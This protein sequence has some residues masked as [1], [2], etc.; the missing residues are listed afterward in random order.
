MVRGFQ[1]QLFPVWAYALLLLGMLFGAMAAQAGLTPAGTPIKNLATVTYQ[2]T[3]GNK[4]TAQSNE[5]VVTVAEIYSADLQKEE[6]HKYGA[7]THTIYFPHQLSNKGNAENSFG[8][9]VA[10]KMP[11][12][13]IVN[14]PGDVIIYDDIDGNGQPD[15]NEPAIG[16]KKL[17]AGEVADLVLAVTVPEGVST[18]EIVITFTATA[19][20]GSPFKVDDKESKSKSVKDTVSIK[21]DIALI[22]ATKKVINHTPAKVVFKD[23]VIDKEES[24][25]GSITYEI[26]VTNKGKEITSADNAKIYDFLPEWLTVVGE[27]KDG[28]TNI[29]SDGTR[30]ESAKATSTDKEKPAL[31]KDDPAYSSR[32]KVV[33]ADIIKLEKEKTSLQFTVNYPALNGDGTA[34]NFET[35]AILRNKAFIV[36]GKEGAREQVET[37][38]TRTVLPGFYNLKALGYDDD[39]SQYTGREHKVASASQGAVVGFKAKIE[40]LSTRSDSYTLSINNE[41]ADVNSFP[42]GTIFSFWQNEEHTLSF[43]NS[44]TTEVA[45]KGAV[46]VYIKAQLP[47]GKKGNNKNY[48]ANLHVVSINSAR[49]GDV[50]LVLGSI[51]APQVD[52]YYKDRTFDSDEEKTSKDANKYTKIKEIHADFTQNGIQQAGTNSTTATNR[53]EVVFSFQVHNDSGISRAFPLFA[54]DGKLSGSDRPYAQGIQ[55]DWEYSFY[56]KAGTVITATDLLP[57]GKSQEVTVKVFVP[58][59]A[60]QQKKTFSVLAGDKARNDALMFF[61]NVESKTSLLLTPPK[62]E[63]QIEAGGTVTY[64]HTLKNTSNRAVTVEITGVNSSRD[65]GWAH[66]VLSIT[67]ADKEGNAIIATS[68]VVNG[69]QVIWSVT[70]PSDVFV[71]IALDVIAPANV[72]GGS[73]DTLTLTATTGSGENQIIVKAEDVT[74]VIKGQIRLHK[75][76]AVIKGACKTNKDEK[77]KWS[78]IEAQAI[79]TL[80]F[81]KDAGKVVPGEDCVVWQII[82]TNQGD[83]PAK[84][85]TIRDAAPAFTTLVEGSGYVEPGKGKV[86]KDTTGG[87]ILFG[88]G[89]KEKTE[90]GKEID[91]T[92]EEGGILQP[93][94]SVEVRFTVKVN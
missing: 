63:N 46:E 58:A 16:S 56:N 22:H 59:N 67:G 73:K 12:G 60:M 21:N 82:A 62:A 81:E 17:A 47:D 89:D 76:A 38:E 7:A 54:Y 77:V 39:T 9:S 11:D 14:K 86:S 94:Q 19:Q 10:A 55:L 26:S 53:Q 20:K 28:Q 31:A 8:F 44:R 57:N 90:E 43:T 34:F 35:D 3:L 32:K 85:V 41:L 45:I 91:F 29:D 50:K 80:A 33:A 88:I 15:A 79:G 27:E 68:K 78:E 4:F 72:L 23:G 48:T 6:Q 51:R 30:I 25:P 65:S 71:D 92:A 24:K 87:K 13:S 40:N 83:A 42:T 75:Q 5:S 93:G 2:D 66:R 49:E 18:G 69:K 64:R 36:W 37:N 74:T 1:R 84:Q 52:L 70:L 61:I